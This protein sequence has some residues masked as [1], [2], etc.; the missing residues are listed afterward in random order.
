MKYCIKILSLFVFIVSFTFAFAV[1][2][3]WV[4]KHGESVEHPKEIFLTGFGIAKVSASSGIENAKQFATDIAKRE[5]TEKVRVSVQNTI[6]TAMQETQEKLLSYFSTVTQSSSQME[7]Q[8]METTIFYD[9]DEE[10]FYVLAFARKDK[11]ISLYGQKAKKMRNT[12]AEHLSSAER[13]VQAN[14]VTKALEEYLLCYPL[15]RELEEAQTILSALQTSLPE[16]G[17]ATAKDEHTILNVRDAVDKLVQ[18][19]MSSDEDIA[20]YIAYCLKNQ[21]EEKN[22]SVLVTPLTFQ[23]TRMGSAFARYFKNVVQNKIID[24]AQWNVVEQIENFTPKTRDV[25]KEFA[26][27]SGAKFVVTGTYWEMGD[28]IKF[29]ISLRD[30]SANRIVGSVEKIVAKNILDRTNLSLKPENYEQALHERKVFNKDEIIGNGLFVEIFTNKG[31]DNILYEEGE[32]MNVSVRVNMPCYVRLVY[33]QA[34]SSRILLLKNYY[35]D[36]SKVNKVVTVPGGWVCAE[37]FGAEVLQVFARTEQFEELN[38]IEQ[39]GREYMQDNLQ[40]FVVATRGMKKVKKE[41]LQAE[42]ILILTTVGK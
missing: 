42:A 26:T 15:F 28:D 1:V 6:S 30:I 4:K 20:W 22:I 13:L 35:I 14:D 36:E 32:R 21:M 27:V 37:P 34:D 29:I 23:D 38:V 24:V 39:D 40:Q 18:R 8:G 11:L 9:D 41:T 12:I 5:M 10:Y 31:Y 2:P 33:H 25:V 16:I 3:D 17:D 19:P 7:I